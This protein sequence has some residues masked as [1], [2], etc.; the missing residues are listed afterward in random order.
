VN[1]TKQP[2]V[3]TIPQREKEVGGVGDD[4]M[5]FFGRRLPPYDADDFFHA[6]PSKNHKIKFHKI[7]NKL[8][9]NSVEAEDGSLGDAAVAAPPPETSFEAKIQGER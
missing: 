7:F 2:G 4:S 6:K 3:Q 9:I 1:P 5:D 8:C